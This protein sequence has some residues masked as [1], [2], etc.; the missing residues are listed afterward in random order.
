MA[1]F[2][3]GSNQPPT[4]SA[5]ID[6]SLTPR[7]FGIKDAVLFCERD[8]LFDLFFR[9]NSLRDHASAAVQNFERKASIFADHQIE[10]NP[11][12]SS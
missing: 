6:N 1:D 5:L 8:R 7:A 4:K 10:A 3:H 12:K 9:F 2:R 11:F